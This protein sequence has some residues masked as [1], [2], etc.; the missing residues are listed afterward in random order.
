MKLRPPNPQPRRCH[1]GCDF[2]HAQLRSYRRT[3][4]ASGCRCQSLK[5]HY[6]GGIEQKNNRDSNRELCFHFC[7]SSAPSVPERAKPACCTKDKA[8]TILECSENSP[9]LA[10]SSAS[11]FAW[12]C[13]RFTSAELMEISEQCCQSGC[14][15]LHLHSRSDS[16]TLTPQIVRR[17]FSYAKGKP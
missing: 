1:Q 13:F 3:S 11:R 9:F 16:S 7:E 10:A 8:S 12:T 5:G 2:L 6:S 15:M 4:E 14:F 17:T